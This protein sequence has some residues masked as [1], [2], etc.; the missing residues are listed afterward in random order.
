MN[1][2]KPLQNNYR[3]KQR[4]AV[5]KLVALLLVAATLF[6]TS[7]WSWFRSEDNQKA[8]AN[9]LQIGTLDEGLEMSIKVNGEYSRFS[10]AID[11]VSYANGELL[12]DLDMIPLTG[13]GYKVS[14]TNKVHLYNP[15]FTYK[16]DGTAVPLQTATVWTEGVA[17]RDYISLEVKFRSV[18]PVIIYLGSGTEVVMRSENNGQPPNISE[19][20]DFSRDAIVGA[21]RMSV[22]DANENLKFIW[23]P[24]PDVRLNKYDDGTYSL[25]SGIEIKDYWAGVHAYYATDANKTSLSR[26]GCAQASGA[27]TATADGGTSLTDK[28]LVGEANTQMEKMLVGNEYKD[29]YVCSAI[30]RIWVDGCDEEAVRA[31]SRGEFNLKLNFVAIL[32]E[33]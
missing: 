6:A 32:D 24:R 2:Q 22:C 33:G 17:N 8:T 20:G 30:F 4:K 5:L 31:L 1:E 13:L 23:I 10:R 9:G 27:F 21:L 19:Y 29:Y 18:D 3:K 11:I 14:S 7:A 28:T 12:K 26:T 25:N 15:V 16:A